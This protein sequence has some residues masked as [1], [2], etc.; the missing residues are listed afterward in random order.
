[1]RM[2]WSRLFTGSR[3]PPLFYDYFFPF[4]LLPCPPLLAWCDWV[5]MIRPEPGPSPWKE[6]LVPRGR[7]RLCED[8]P[9]RSLAHG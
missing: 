5:A 7:L 1:M 8:G 3:S 9:S 2:A 6:K 4:F